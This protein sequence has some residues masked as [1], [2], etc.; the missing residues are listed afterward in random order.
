[1]NTDN[2]KARLIQSSGLPKAAFDGYAQIDLIGNEEAIIDGCKGIIEYSEDKITL[3]LG[4][5]CA[6]FCGDGLS[7]NAFD[8]EQTVIRGN[9]LSIQFS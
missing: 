6:S 1:M 8:C 3:N 4:K 7:M 2:I 5:I 9:F